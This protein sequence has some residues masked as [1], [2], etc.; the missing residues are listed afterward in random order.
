MR[1]KMLT[2]NTNENE[3][4]TGDNKLEGVNETHIRRKL[5]SNRLGW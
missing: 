2:L 3:N 4:K 1:E 5:Q